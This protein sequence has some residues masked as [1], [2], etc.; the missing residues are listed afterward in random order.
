MP[1]AKVSRKRLMRHPRI[2]LTLPAAFLLTPTTALAAAAEGEVELLVINPGLLIWTLVIFNSLFLVLRRFAWKPILSV[3]EERESTIRVALDEARRRQAEAQELMRRQ[4]EELAEARSQARQTL[5]K[6]REAVDRFR[7]EMERRTREESEELLVRA[8]EAIRQERE[9]AVEALRR[10]SVDL[11]L[12][13]AS[14][15]LRQELDD[16]QDRRFVMEYLGGLS[17]LN[18]KPGARA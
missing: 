15:L 2:L 4:E 3:A 13:T 8:R 6:N 18:P 7:K 10:E 11:A 9:D 16:G 1:D 14:K 17:T 5:A 12:A